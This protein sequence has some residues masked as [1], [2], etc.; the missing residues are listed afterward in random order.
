MDPQQVPLSSAH[1]ENRFPS[2]PPAAARVSSGTWLERTGKT[3]RPWRV[4]ETTPAASGD[5]C[6]MGEIKWIDGE[7]PVVRALAHSTHLT[8]VATWVVFLGHGDGGAGE[9]ITIEGCHCMEMDYQ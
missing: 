6:R 9:G 5:A 3:R 1:A 8:A 4:A 7:T 2:P